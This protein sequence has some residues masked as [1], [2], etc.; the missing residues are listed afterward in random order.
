MYY[1]FGHFC[2]G[3]TISGDLGLL[4]ALEITCLT[5]ATCS[6][7]EIS[8]FQITNSSYCLKFLD[9]FSNLNVGP[10]SSSHFY[11]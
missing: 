4:G 1:R 11:M 5:N 3:Y 2:G 9:V 8:F 6:N 7:V 10:S